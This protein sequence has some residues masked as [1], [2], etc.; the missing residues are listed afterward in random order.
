MGSNVWVVGMLRDGSFVGD[1]Q[2]GRMNPKPGF[3]SDSLHV[4]HANT[5]GRITPSAI[6]FRGESYSF[7]MSDHQMTTGGDRPFTTKA[8]LATGDHSF[9]YTSGVHPEIF[10]FDSDGRLQRI[11]RLGRALM[12][13]TSADIARFREQDLN[14]VRTE[15]FNI[16]S[17]RGTALKLEEAVLDWMPFPKTMPEFT[18]LHVDPSGGIWVRDYGD[19][20]KAESWEAFDRTGRWLGTVAMPA[21]LDVFGIGLDYVLGRVKDEDDVESVQLYRLLH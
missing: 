5:A 3:Y 18:A 2:L 7:E 11:I 9:F 1:Y 6:L 15:K 21:G 12:P 19:S 14:E 10:E 13:V 8:S 4:V 20:T 16:E 17:S